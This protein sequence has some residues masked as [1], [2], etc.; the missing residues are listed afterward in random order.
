M[1]NQQVAM[2]TSPEKQSTSKEVCFREYNIIQ[3]AR[4]LAEAR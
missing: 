4:A 3:S 2:S 1:L